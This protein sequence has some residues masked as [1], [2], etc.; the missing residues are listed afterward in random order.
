MEERQDWAPSTWSPAETLA[1][2]RK[3]WEIYKRHELLAIAVQGLFWAG[4]TA[5]LDEGGY[6][7][8]A[9]SY[10]RWFGRRFQRVLGRPASSSFSIQLE[11]RRKSQPKLSDRQSPEHEINPGEALLS[12]QNED[13]VDQVVDLSSRILLALLARGIDGAAFVVEVPQNRTA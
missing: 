1:E 12:A 3:G 9:S 8:D 4:L 13:D 11:T 10:A 2:V 6:V 5:L 7:E